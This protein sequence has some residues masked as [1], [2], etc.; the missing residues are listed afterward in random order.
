M[1]RWARY[2]LPVVW[3][4][5]LASAAVPP[6]AARADVFW[7]ENG[8][9]IEGQWLNRD[10]QPPTRYV[11]RRAGMTL[12]LPLAQ[13]REAV[14]QTPAEQEYARRAPAA[15]DTAAQQWELAEWCRRG[16]LLPQR[17][18]HLRR[19]IELDPNHAQARAALG[20]QFLQ[21]A[22][23]T[24]A[25]FQRNGGRELYKGK[26]RTPQEIEI[27]ENR[28]RTELAEKEWLKRL[29]RWRKE[30]DDREKAKTAYAALTAIKDP[31]ASGPIDALFSRERVRGV[32]S[33]YADA[34]TN[35][36]TTASLRA[37]AE[38]ALG[39][40]DEEVFYYCVDRL[41]AVRPPHIADPFVAA[42]KDNRNVRV[43]R[44]AIALAR[45]NEKSSIS[46]LIDAL[47][48]T[49]TEIVK[50]DPLAGADTTAFGSFGAYSKKGDDGPKLNIYHIQ[51][52]AVL[53]S[54]TK[55]TGVNFSFDKKA[56]RYWYAQEKIAQEAGQP[57]V[58]ARRQ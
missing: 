9:Q 45:L 53:D 26:W 58:D 40:A 33:I 4:Q 18:A 19:V 10:E 5:L 43:N 39:D 55:L 50:P 42:L 13:V 30:L 34:L 35:I 21:G 12:V 41:A 27:L 48:T 24:R 44:G 52:Q 25:D 3:A 38:R 1:V 56:W 54:L 51:N 37:L 22:W 36:N 28:S 46:P 11:I 17:E 15:E 7:L 32:K 57:V 20:F 16:S 47:E 8:G 23:I 2:A 29:Q 6:P 31:L 14:R 49:H